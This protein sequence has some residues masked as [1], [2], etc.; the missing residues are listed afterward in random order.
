MQ[1]MTR[2]RKFN[3]PSF[4]VDVPNTTPC[5]PVELCPYLKDRTIIYQGPPTLVGKIQPL[6]TIEIADEY[7]GDYDDGDGKLI[8][9]CYPLPATIH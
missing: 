5:R 1:G 6:D 9:Q 8:M 4:V 2:L 3:D 7:L